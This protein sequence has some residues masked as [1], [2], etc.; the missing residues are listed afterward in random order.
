MYLTRTNIQKYIL[1]IFIM[2][3]LYKISLEE[4]KEYIPVL[5]DIL[6]FATIQIVTHIFICLTKTEADLFDPD[7]FQTLFF[8]ILSIIIYWFIVK[9]FF[10]LK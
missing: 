8:L 10:N 2:T 5:N 9:K 3:F 7:F 4:N 6:R 1:R